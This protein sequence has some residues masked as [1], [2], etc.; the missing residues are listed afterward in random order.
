MSNLTL[1]ATLYGSKKPIPFLYVCQM[2]DSKP[3]LHTA[4]KKVFIVFSWVWAIFCIIV[5]FCV[6]VFIVVCCGIAAEGNKNS[7]AGGIEIESWNTLQ[8]V[9]TLG[10]YFLWWRLSMWQQKEY[11]AL[12]SRF[13]RPTLWNNFCL[14]LCYTFILFIMLFEC[15]WFYRACAVIRNISHNNQSHFNYN[16]SKMWYCTFSF[17]NCITFYFFLS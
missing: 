12:T 8:C 7:K 11:K 17:H 15:D 4:V 14:F 1:P 2:N 9:V 10:S 5:L 3:I 6:A 16:K 13:N